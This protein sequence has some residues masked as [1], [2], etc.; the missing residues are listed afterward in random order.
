M[1][2]RR[3]DGAEG[4]DGVE[5]TEGQGVGEG[6]LWGGF[7]GRAEDD[8]EVDCGVDFC[9]SGVG[10]ELIFVQGEDGGEGFEGATGTD[11]VAVKRLGGAD[12]DLCGAGTEDLVDGGGF[13]GVV[14][15]GSSAVGADESDFVGICVCVLE[16]SD[17][18]AGCSLGVGLGDVAGVGGAAGADDLGVDMGVAG[19]GGFEGFEGEHGGAFAE[20]HA[21]AVGGEGAALGGRDDAHAVPGAEEAEGERGFVAA[22]DCCFDHSAANH[23]EG[24]ADGMGAG[25]AGCGDV[26]GRA[27]DLLVDGDVAGASGGHSTDDG[28]GMNAGVAGVE[29]V[30]LGLFGLSATAGAA[31]DDG[32]SFGVVVACNLGF[33]GGL[34]SRDDGKVGGAVGCADDAG[35]EMLAGVEVLYGGCAGEAKA[36]GL[37]GGFGVWGEG[38]DAGGSAE[39]GGAEGCDGVADWGDAAKT[40]NYD[41]IHFFSILVL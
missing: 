27:G 31:Y 30:G 16:R 12:R 15:L 24:K 25:G 2:R 1:D 29:L 13:G 22:C 6:Q 18:G 40:C 39:E 4:Q 7:T 20:G 26:E 14:D 19:P 37:A 33:G 28:E 38:C 34:T 9:D 17:H 11:G 10:G 8:V 36:L 41:T 5:A 35:F 23:L 3:S 32:D 21:V